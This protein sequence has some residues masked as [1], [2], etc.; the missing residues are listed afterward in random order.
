M[1]ETASADPRLDR[2]LRS[3]PRLAAT[4]ALVPHRY[5]GRTWY[6]LRAPGA[7]AHWLL[8]RPAFEFVVALDGERTVAEIVAAIDLETDDVLALLA[9]LLE[10]DALEGDL[11]PG[12]LARLEAERGAR[13]KRRLQALGR[14]LSIRIPLID[15]E[16]ALRALQ[17]LAHAL[18]SRLGALLWSLLVLAGAVTALREAPALGA[19]FSARFMDPT[20]LVALWFVYPVVKGLHEFG[21]GLAARRF[22]TP[23]RELGVMLLVFVPVPYVDASATSAFRSARHRMIVAAAGIATELLLAAVAILVW[24]TLAPGLL[25][26]LLFDVAVVGGVSTLLFNGNPLLRFDGYYV[27]VDALEI[28]N[29]GTRAQRHL[30]R[31]LRRHVLG[32][33]E[34]EPDLAPGEGPWLLAYGLAAGI[35]RLFVSVAIALFV[36]SSFFVI[37]ALLAL[38]FLWQQF[39]GP[40]VRGLGT[41]VPRVVAAGRLPRLAMVSGG[42]CLAGA[43]LLFGAPV[44]RTTVADAILAPPEGSVIRAG[45]SGFVRRG[46]LP[47]GAPVA[48]ADVLLALENP[49]LEADVVRLEARRAELRALRSLAQS[50]DRVEAQRLGDELA[51]AEAEL[52]RVSGERDRLNLLAPAAGV[53]SWTTPSRSGRYVERGDV[54]GFVTGG[55]DWRLRAFVDQRGMGRLREGVAR[56]DVVSRSAPERKTVGALH[57]ETPRAVE[58]LPDRTL[59]T[60][61]GGAI[62]VDQRDPEGR[63]LLAPMFEIEVRLPEAEPDAYRVGQRF[64][65]RFV[66]SPRAVGPRLYDG[67]RE[68]LRERLDW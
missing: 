41:L 52:A 27:L 34:A 56:I 8:D 61:G 49:E 24:T 20:N 39:V 58:R 65:V 21:H 67:L 68:L 2:V 38:W 12:P 31:L 57:S 5:R 53:L 46:A 60:G 37:G 63:R 47:T 4:A 11:A 54:L 29:L 55:D 25:R 13:R 18:F 33:D 14:P 51:A 7:G 62:P 9:T 22:G 19:H 17:P 50:E 64:L 32:L 28:P 15:P 36:G 66:H 23:V 3:R 48:R 43:L 44:A 26:D 59:G 42:L 40:L 35:Y 30:G 6:L 1:S 16:P 10:A 45:A